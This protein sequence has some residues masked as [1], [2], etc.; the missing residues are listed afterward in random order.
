MNKIIISY[1]NVCVYFRYPYFIARILLGAIDHNMHLF[2]P[3]AKTKQGNLCYARKYTKRTK[4]WHAE[5]LKEAKT[6][7]YIPLLLARILKRRM[8]K[9]GSVLDAVPRSE[10][11][12]K[13]ISPSIAMAVPPPTHVLI[14][15][16]LSRF[17]SKSGV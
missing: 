5:P 12:P 4:R 6:Y 14:Q 17:A 15:E 8:E 9:E 7:K 2:R 13:N 1:F 11:D 3:P 16:K 10:N